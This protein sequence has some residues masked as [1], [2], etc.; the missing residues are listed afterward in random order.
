MYCGS[1][2]V[3]DSDASSKKTIYTYITVSRKAQAAESRIYD[4]IP[5][6]KVRWC[7]S[8]V[9]TT[10]PEQFLNT[11]HLALPPLHLASATTILA[12]PAHSLQVCPSSELAQ[13]P[14]VTLCQAARGPMALRLC[15]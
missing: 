1:M 2:L 7:Y 14:Q 9:S 6:S 4:E 15:P 12:Q 3:Y 11:P 5:Q 13:L 10:T 8:L